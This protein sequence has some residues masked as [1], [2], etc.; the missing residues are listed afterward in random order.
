MSEG[1]KPLG[2]ISIDVKVNLKDDIS[3]W[4][5]VVWLGVAT[6]SWLFGDM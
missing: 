2:R 6:N 3:V 5:G 4:V 1:N